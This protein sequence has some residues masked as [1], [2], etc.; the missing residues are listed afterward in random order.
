MPYVVDD[1]DFSKMMVEIQVQNTLSD[2]L[3]EQV[4]YMKWS[5]YLVVVLEVV[6]L[7]MFYFE[8][9]YPHLVK[10]WFCPPESD[11]TVPLVSN[12]V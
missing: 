12:A 2:K 5:C 6:A 8:W 4:D 7:G 1:A 9:R 3:L 10:K 11:K